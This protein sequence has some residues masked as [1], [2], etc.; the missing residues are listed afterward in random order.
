MGTLKFQKRAVLPGLF[1]IIGSGLIGMMVA[2]PFIMNK[3]DAALGLLESFTVGVVIAICGT[4]AFT[5][6]VRNVRTRTVWAFLLV[7]AI[8]AA[9][10]N[11]GALIFGFNAFYPLLTMTVLAE[12]TGMTLT[13][14]MYRYSTRLNEQLIRAQE[15]LKRLND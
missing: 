6:T 10:T 13:Y 15:R 9:G 7:A 5:F 14:M 8:I 11:G 4:F 12:M 1:G 2:F 3:S